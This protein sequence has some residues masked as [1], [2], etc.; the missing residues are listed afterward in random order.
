[1]PESQKEGGRRC[2]EMRKDGSPCLAF[3]LGEKYPVE[4]NHLTT[5]ELGGS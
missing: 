2:S 1:M 4:P 3:A 5:E